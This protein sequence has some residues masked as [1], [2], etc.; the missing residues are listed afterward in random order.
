MALTKQQ[1]RNRALQEMQVLAAGQTPSGEDAALVEAIIDEAFSQYESVFPFVVDSTPDWAAEPM[2]KLI[3]ARA[4]PKFGNAP[5]TLSE[6]DALGIISHE[7]EVRMPSA[8]EPYDF[9]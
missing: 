1:L 5:I 9:F 6:R 3:A 4:S 7:R 2:A 8:P